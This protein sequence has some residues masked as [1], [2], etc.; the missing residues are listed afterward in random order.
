MAE[1]E[2]Q[3]ETQVETQVETQEQAGKWYDSLDADLRNNPTIQKYESAEA[4]HKGHLELAASFGKDKVVWPKDENDA[5]A[6]AEINKRMGVPD[7]PDGYDLEAIANPEGVAL[8]DRAGFQEIMHANNAPASVAKGLWESYA[9]GMNAKYEE[10]NAQFNA[11]VEAGK[12]ELMKE[13]GEAYESKV[14]GADAVIDTLSKSQAQKDALTVSLSQSPDGLRFLAEIHSM[15]KESSIGGFQ[16][17]SSFTK[18][19]DEARQEIDTIKAN[20]DYRSEDI[21]VRQPLIDRVTALRKMATPGN[22]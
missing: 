20:P 9:N 8:F 11:N 13:W 5:S 2:Q 7:K 14:K 15:M 17:K 18:T 22:S 4:A 6:W 19:P 3:Q 21:R 12:A 1:E 16:E 10:A